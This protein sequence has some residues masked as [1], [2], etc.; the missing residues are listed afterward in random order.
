VATE[1][2]LR[3]NFLYKR[4]K[5]HPATAR[6]WA[7]RLGVSI[8]RKRGSRIKL[9]FQQAYLLSLIALLRKQGVSFQ[10]AIMIAQHVQKVNHF[11]QNSDYF[12]KR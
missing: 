3:L 8:P 4:F 6:R 12:D 2:A 9:S 11:L 5:I 1:N 7:L 10:K